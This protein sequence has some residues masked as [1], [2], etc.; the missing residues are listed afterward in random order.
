MLSNI[1]E[2][3]EQ[4][5]IRLQFWHI[6]QL[7]SLYLRNIY[8]PCYDIHLN[9]GLLIVTSYTRYLRTVYPPVRLYLSVSVCFS[10]TLFSPFPVMFLC[11]FVSSA[12]CGAVI[13][14]LSKTNVFT[15]RRFTIQEKKL[16]NKNSIMSRD[17]LNLEMKEKI[18]L[19][20]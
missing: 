18:L 6:Q 20:I 5:F 2:I 16:R 7:H 19:S 4:H 14:E 12:E 11:I 9:F 17:N 3:L 1:F 15:A 8:Y 13:R 10:L